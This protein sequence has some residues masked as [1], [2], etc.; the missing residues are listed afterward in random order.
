MHQAAQVNTTVP[1]GIQNSSTAIPHLARTEAS[2]GKAPRRDLVHAEA[3][4]MSP[5]VAAPPQPQSTPTV[6]QNNTGLPNRLKAG[7]ESLSGMSMDHVR[8]HYNSPKPAQVSALAYAQGNTIHVAP[9]QERHLPHEAWHIVQQAQGRVKPTMQMKGGASVNDNGGLERE[10]DVMGARAMAFQ[11]VGGL[12][13][14]TNDMP[15]NESRSGI[16]GH[17][18]DA[19]LQRKRIDSTGVDAAKSGTNLFTEFNNET[20]KLTKEVKE[21]ASDLEKGEAKTTTPASGKKGAKKRASGKKSTKKSR[22]I[23]ALSDPEKEKDKDKEKD[24][25]SQEKALGFLEWCK[26][27]TQASQRYYTE[28][29]SAEFDMPN[30]IFGKSD[31][32]DPD[33]TRFDPSRPDQVTAIEVK[34]SDA[35]SFGRVNDLVQE[36]INQLR[37]R[38][39]AKQLGDKKY[40]DHLL[41]IFVE[42]KKNIWPFTVREYEKEKKNGNP[43]DSAK[44][45]LQKKLEKIIKNIK[46]DDPVNINKL[47]L[48]F[49]SKLLDT[50]TLEYEADKSG[51]FLL[52]KST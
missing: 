6:P 22:N 48:K 3:N 26:S 8:V 29:Y 35:D 39:K 13:S 16:T 43:N 5:T 17:H 9:G 14:H 51:N 49:S 2:F 44:E 32:D 12:Y 11:S 30:I 31:K 23:T 10:A 19:T 37:K 18:K 28:W 52:K 7:V 33:F 15:K 42:N 36:G 45:H 38:G 46:D 1:A 25:F 24:N 50:I 40:T 41:Y 21:Y 47:T 27:A 20:G 34:R 4:M